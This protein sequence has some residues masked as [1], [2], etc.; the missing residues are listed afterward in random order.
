MT[1][2]KG[3]PIGLPFVSVV[4]FSAHMVHA[5][6]ALWMQPIR[7]LKSDTPFGWSMPHCWA[8]AWSAPQPFAQVMSALH[9]VFMLQATFSASQQPPEACAL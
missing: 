5:L 1:H 9:S 8:Q 4:V 3:S 7:V 6:Q 2:E